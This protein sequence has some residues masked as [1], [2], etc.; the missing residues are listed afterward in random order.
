MVTR[1][2]RGRTPF[3]ADQQH[4]HHLLLRNGVSHRVAVLL[5]YFFG[6]A[7]GIS[8]LLLPTKGKILMLGILLV[9]GWGAAAILEK[10]LWKK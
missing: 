9:V 1:V 6:T 8:A 7:F 3:A 2:A 5:Y 10:K 4:L